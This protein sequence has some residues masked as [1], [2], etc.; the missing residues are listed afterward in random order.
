MRIVFDGQWILTQEIL[1]EL[2][3]MFIQE[4]QK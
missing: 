1:D 3:N 4:K 2:F